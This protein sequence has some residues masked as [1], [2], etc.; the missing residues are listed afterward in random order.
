VLNRLAAL[1]GM[2]E[3]QIAQQIRLCSATVSQ[4]CWAGSPYQ[5]VPVATDVPQAIGMEILEDHDK[6]PGITAQAAA[7]RTYPAP[8]G[9]NAAQML[10]YL[11]PVTS[12]ELSKPGNDFQ[13][14]DM[15]GRAGLEAE[16]R[17]GPA[18]PLRRRGGRG[19]QPRPRGAHGLADRARA[20]RRHRDHHRRARAAGRGAGLAGAIQSTR[21]VWDK[22]TNSY[23][24]ANSG[25]VVVLN[26]NTGGVVAMASYPTYDPN[27]VDRRHQPA[28]IRAAHQHGRRHPAAGSRISGRVPAGLDVQGRDHL[29]DAAGRLPL[30]RHIPRLRG[31]RS[32]EFFT[33]QIEILRGPGSSF[34]GRGTTGGAI[35]IVTKQATTEKS[36]YNMDT[37]FSTDPGARVTL[38]VN[39]VINPTLAIRAAAC[40]RTLISPGAIMPPMIAAAAS[41]Q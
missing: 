20:R 3:K 27:V 22:E 10:G 36:F 19:G 7:V 33:E 23:G 13:P 4:P 38:D 18:R 6:F 5:P 12:G 32:R 1:L 2:P 9:A 26:V 25:A 30:R 8:F 16:V 41:L 15:V 24:K 11:S 37:T 39:Q 28:G 40:S 21:S 35:N 31:Q 29:G 17:L 34:A 14:T